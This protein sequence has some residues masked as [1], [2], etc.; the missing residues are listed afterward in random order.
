MPD[1]A[2]NKTQDPDVKKKLPVKALVIL[3]VIMLLEGGIFVA[4]MYAL[5]PDSS[6][7]AVTDD[8]SAEPPNTT[9]E[10]MII[11]CRAVPSRQ[12]GRTVLYDFEVHVVCDKEDDVLLAEFAKKHEADIL[13]RFRTIIAKADP[14]WFD[15]AE[16]VTMKKQIKIMLEEVVGEGMIQRV[17]IPSWRSY[18]QSF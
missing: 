14:N 4:C 10:R 3:L 9:L 15:E 7:G 5:D 2:E 17:L 13:D 1:E 6:S 8:A 11:Q 18:P 16:L 12:K